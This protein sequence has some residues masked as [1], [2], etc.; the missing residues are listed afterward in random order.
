MAIRSAL[1]GMTERAQAI[2]RPPC[3]QNHGYSTN[4]Q[5]CTW[6]FARRSGQWA[7]G[8]PAQGAT[9][10]DS[11]GTPHSSASV[12]QPPLQQDTMLG[13][14]ARGGDSISTRLLQS[15]AGQVQ[16]PLLTQ[17]PLHPQAQAPGRLAQAEGAVR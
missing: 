10:D 4:G 14:S 16:I 11:R 13:V 9:A 1:S 15:L 3:E 12:A 6:C 7:T 2:H 8:G 17:T 5:S